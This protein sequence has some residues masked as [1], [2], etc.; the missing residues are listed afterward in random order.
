V[1]SVV[2][3][4][5]AKKYVITEDDYSYEP[6]G[7]ALRRNDTAMRTAVNRALAGLYRGEGIAEIYK[8]WFAPF[9][10]PGTLLQAMYYLNALPE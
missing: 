3:G 5:D 4:R 1:G 9:G 8:R 2:R 7:L 10:P 6:Y